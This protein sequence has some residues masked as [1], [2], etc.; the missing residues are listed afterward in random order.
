[1]DSRRQ[2]KIAHL[3]QEVFGNLLQREGRSII[4]NT[5]MT[6]TQVKVTPDLSVARIYISI[7]AEPNAPTII[8]AMNKNKLE[9]RRLVGNDMRHD[10]RKIPELEFYLDDTLDYVEKM[11]KLFKKIHQED[12]DI[13]QS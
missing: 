3:I 10:L 8:K 7:L 6:V 11:D 2:S 4:G 12:Q 9:F 1:M 13:Q 5:F